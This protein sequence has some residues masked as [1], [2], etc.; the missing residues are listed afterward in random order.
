VSASVT[1]SVGFAAFFAHIVILPLWLQQNL[2]YTATWAGYATGMMGIFAVL[3]APV[4]GQMA[5]KVD[6]RRIIFV[7]VLGLAGLA[8]WRMAFTSQVTFWQMAIPTLLTGPF[9]VMF[10]IPTTGLAIASVAPGEEANA[11][12]LSNFMR[13]LAGA[14]A[15]SLVQT[16]WANEASRAQTGLAGAM[17]MGSST[18][19]AMVAGGQ[20]REGAIAALDAMVQGQSV[21]L[22]TVHVFGMIAVGFVIAAGMVWLAPRPK[23]PIDMSGG[24]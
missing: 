12:G 2:G 20:S 17:P 3:S 9:M 14:F 18:I 4:I 8:V 23:G 7:G 5:E 1:Y 22:A 21:M 10:F 15:T 13:T 19:D 24:H 16:T 11:A 6:P